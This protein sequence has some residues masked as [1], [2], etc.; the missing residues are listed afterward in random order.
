MPVQFLK[1]ILPSGLMRITRRS[2]V[3][4][5]LNSM[6]LPVTLEQIRLW[7]GGTLIQDAMPN[8]TS[9]ER[10]FLISG[11]TELEQKELFADANL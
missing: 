1:T 8:L 6:D 2:L 10:E 4:G 5:K 11:L 3:S 7:E 9:T